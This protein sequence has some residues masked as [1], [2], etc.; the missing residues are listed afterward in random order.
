[1][2]VNQQLIQNPTPGIRM[3]KFCGDTVTFRRKWPYV[4]NGTAWSR[5]NIGQSKVIRQEIIRQIDAG[6]FIVRFAFVHLFFYAATC[7]HRISDI[8]IKFLVCWMSD[9]M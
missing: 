7:F 3:V 1:M 9:R 5:T 6:E 2:E 4:Q 8:F